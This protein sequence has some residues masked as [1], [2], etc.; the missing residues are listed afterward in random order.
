[1]K[2]NIAPAAQTLNELVASGEENS[3]DFAFI[4][5]DKTGYDEYYEICLRLIRKGGIIA[6]DN[7]LWSGSVI[8]DN[9][10]TADTV[11]LRK[12]NVKLANDARVT[13]VQMN[14]GDGLTLVTK[15]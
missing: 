9:V 13:T 14:I 11:A 2:L 4:D 10:Q 7:T 5:A 12:L 1:M 15:L 3:F 8:D 6:I